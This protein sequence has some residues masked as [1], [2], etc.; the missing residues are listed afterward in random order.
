MDFITHL[1]DRR[2]KVTPQRTSILKILS[3]HTHPNIEELYEEIRKEFP[4]ISLATVYKNL[5]ILKQTGMVLEING[6]ISKPRLD[7][8]THPHAHIVCKNCG[9]IEDADF[10]KSIHKYK[11]ELKKSTLYEITQLDVVVVVACCKHC[12]KN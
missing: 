2:L 3:R 6:N 9:A 5:N 12:K 4:T 11:R 7:I 8:Y 10:M 1:R